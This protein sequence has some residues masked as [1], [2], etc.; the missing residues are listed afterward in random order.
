VRPFPNAGDGKWPA[1]TDGGMA[2]LWA[3]NGR[4]L[5]F[6]NAQRR[7]TAITF[8]AGTPPQLGERRVLFTLAPEDYLD[9]NT[10]YTPFDVGPDGRFLIARRV[11]SPAEAPLIV[12]ENWFTE[13]QQKLQDR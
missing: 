3:R 2:P 8:T 1:S 7:M 11:R 4:E 6:V 5:Y 9:G 13:L 10:Y 12:V